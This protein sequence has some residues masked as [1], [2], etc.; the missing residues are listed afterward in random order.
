MMIKDDII[1]YTVYESMIYDVH[2][3]HTS[4]IN[5]IILY[6]YKSVHVVRGL[7]LY[8]Y[9]MRGMFRW[10]RICIYWCSRYK[11]YFIVYDMI[12]IY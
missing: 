11:N 10:G 5:D 3:S 7:K 1:H 12:R 2:L 9:E 4:H 8:N 6:E